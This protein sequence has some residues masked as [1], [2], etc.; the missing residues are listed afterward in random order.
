MDSPNSG[1]RL[2]NKT[3]QN[4]VLLPKPKNTILQG[5]S[6]SNRKIIIKYRFNFNPPCL[7]VRKNIMH[8]E[9]VFAFV[10]RVLG[11]MQYKWVTDIVHA[12]KGRSKQFLSRPLENRKPRE[13]KTPLKINRS[14]RILLVKKGPEV[15]WHG[16][17]TEQYNTRRW[18]SWQFGNSTYPPREN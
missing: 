9:I 8:T 13:F 10:K 14:I 6:R 16:Q 18:Q 7:P 2:E 4:I 12:A 15:V 11:M 17:T 1:K 3:K 5:I